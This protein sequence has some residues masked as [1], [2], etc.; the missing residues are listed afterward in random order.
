MLK[1]AVHAWD[2]PTMVYP[3]FRRAKAAWRKAMKESY[4]AW[5]K[6]Y[7]GNHADL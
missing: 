6:P 1:Y 7:R 2:A 3:S 4:T 5:T